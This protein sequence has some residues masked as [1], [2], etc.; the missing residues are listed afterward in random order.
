[1]KVWDR[2]RPALNLLIYGFV[3]LKCRDDGEMEQA[4]QAEGNKTQTPSVDPCV[5]RGQ[6]EWVRGRR[7]PG[8]GGAAAAAACTQPGDWRGET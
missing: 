2:D 4:F 7:P 3:M 6:D 8:A 1:M 5:C